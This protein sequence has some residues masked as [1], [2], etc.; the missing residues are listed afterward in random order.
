MGNFLHLA[1]FPRKM[2]DGNFLEEGMYSKLL[3]KL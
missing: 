2:V 1:P 3:M